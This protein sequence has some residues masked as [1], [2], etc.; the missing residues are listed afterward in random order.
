MSGGRWRCLILVDDLNPSDVGRVVRYYEANLKD[1]YM[2]I[3]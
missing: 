1:Y 2:R 3:A